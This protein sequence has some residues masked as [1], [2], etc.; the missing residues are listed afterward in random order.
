MHD[1]LAILKAYAITLGWA[2]VGALSMGVALIVTL[3]IFTLSTR[4]VD[5]WKLVKD[6]NIPIAIIMGS[7]AVSCGLVVA[8]CVRP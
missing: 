4:E 2:L 5:E 7:V 3:R 1:L 6:G 8:A